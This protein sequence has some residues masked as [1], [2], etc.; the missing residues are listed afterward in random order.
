VGFAGVRIRD[1]NQ[2]GVLEIEREPFV[3]SGRDLVRAALRAEELDR[4][5]ADG[6]V[7]LA[8]NCFNR[9]LYAK[10]STGKQIAHSA[11]LEGQPLPQTAFLN[12]G[13]STS[14]GTCRRDL[15]LAMLDGWS[16]S[17]SLQ[18]S[19]STWVLHLLPKRGYFF[20]VFH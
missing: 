6:C 20:Q 17:Q 2:P 3:T 14:R 8:T 12:G 19:F 16:K 9:K 1:F 18:G 15:P 10:S 7:S 4:L 5:C 11:W 13:T